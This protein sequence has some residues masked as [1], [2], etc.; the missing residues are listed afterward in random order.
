MSFSGQMHSLVLLDKKDRVLRNGILWN[1]IQKK[2]YGL[3]KMNQM[4][5]SE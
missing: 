2:C 4:F 3:K 5:K 1:D